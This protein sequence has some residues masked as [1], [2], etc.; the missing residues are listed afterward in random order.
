MNKRYFLFFLMSMFLFSCTKKRERTTD[1]QQFNLKNWVCVYS[2]SV[3]PDDIKKFDL[4]V[5]DADAHPALDS[6]KNSGTLL[7]GYIS[8]AEVGSYRWYWRQISAQP[9]VLDKNPD[10]DSYMLDV[11]DKD[12]QKIVLKEIIPAILEQGFDGLFLDTIDTAEY[13]EKYHLSQKYPGS[14]AAMVQLI[15]KIRWQYPQIYIIAN[16]GFSMLNDFGWAVDGVVA[17]SVLTEFNHEQQALNFNS[18]NA[19]NARLAFLRNAK[20]QYNLEVFTLDYVGETGDF[21][22]NQVTA[23][24]RE[25][26]FIPYISTRNLNKIHFTETEE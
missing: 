12:W 8:L 22:T 15:E 26:G 14:Q 18:D 6:L 10:W 4:A 16:R 11:R 17:E 2:D 20:M 1:L 24:A 3:K 25:Q 21:D 19:H 23:K 9:W 13:L 5:L 7:F